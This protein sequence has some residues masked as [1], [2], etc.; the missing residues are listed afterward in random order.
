[1]GGNLQAN[2]GNTGIG[3]GDIAGAV[4]GGAAGAKGLSVLKDKIFGPKGGTPPVAEGV[5]GAA[6]KPGFFEKIFGK[7]GASIADEAHGIRAPGSPA[8]A[9]GAAEAGAAGKAGGWFGKL[10]KF[11]GAGGEVLSKAAA[12]LT[13]AMTMAENMDELKETGAVDPLKQ[14][15]KAGSGLDKVFSTDQPFFSMSRLKGAGEAISG[16]TG[17]VYR[18]GHPNR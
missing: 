14:A 2:M 16:A 5:A 1:M 7:S 6:K 3:F 8:G 10:G 9:A 17:A 18:S 12:P 15:M 13:I 4:I 11:F